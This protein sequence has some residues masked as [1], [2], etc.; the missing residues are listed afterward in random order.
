MAIFPALV[1]GAIEV[2]ASFVRG[3]SNADDV[4]N[5][6]DMV[7][8]LNYLFTLGVAPPCLDAADTNDDGAINLVDVID[9]GNHLFVFAPPPPPPHP[10][11]GLDPTA[12]MLDCVASSPMCP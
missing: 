7:Y 1:D 3:D 2:Q 4:L 5:L 10:S 12:D 6:V 11:C 8:T 9:L